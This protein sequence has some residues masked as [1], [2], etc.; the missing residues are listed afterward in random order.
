M[1]RGE[2]AG[3]Q[4]SDIDFDKAVISV[5]REIVFVP[6]KGHLVTPPKSAKS[7]RAIDIT[8][9]DVV[10]LQR[11]SAVQA[12]QRLRAGPAWKDENWV[13]TR[14]DGD[15]IIPNDLS[16]AFRALCDRLGLPPVRLHDLRHPHASIM[17]LAGVH[18]KVVQERLGHASVGITG[19][20]Y[21]HVAPGL[22]KAAALSFEA[23]LTEHTHNA[24]EEVH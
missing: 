7:R 11:H 22:Q 8:A 19:D 4:W 17:L 18:L 6:G 24:T 5:K 21:S 1:R 15:H 14:P 13:F 2:V 12:E 3:L 10:S 16:K 23:E 9:S 20:T